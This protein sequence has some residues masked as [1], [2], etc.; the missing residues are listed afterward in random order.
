MDVTMERFP[1]KVEDNV[2]YLGACWLKASQ[3]MLIHDEQSTEV[4]ASHV[5]S[6][7]NCQ[8]LVNL[9]VKKIVDAY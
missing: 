8:V 5:K 6:V 1:N 9:F 7:F 3:L 4:S 2:Y